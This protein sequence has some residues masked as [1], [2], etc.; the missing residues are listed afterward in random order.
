MAEL[1]RRRRLPDPLTTLFEQQRQFILDPSRRKAAFVARR[2]GKSFAI[3]AYLIRECLRT[4]RTK[5][6]YYGLTRESAWGVMYLHIIDEICRK[7]RLHVHINQ[8]LQTVR[9]DNQSIIKFTGDDADDKQIDKALGGKYRLVVFDECQSINHDL[10]RWI[11]EKLGPAMVDV[12]GTICLC[13]TAGNLMGDR[14]WYRVTRQDGREREPGW[15]VHSWTPFDNP[16]MADR[17]RVELERLKELNPHIEEDPGYRQQ[18]LC[19]W[20]IET[21]G[22]IYRYNPTRN[23][24]TVPDKVVE[25]LSV[26]KGWRY[27]VGMD[28]GFRDDTAFVLGAYHPHDPTLYIVESYKQS[29]MTALAVAGIVN[30]WRAKYKPVHIVGDCQ[31]RQFV[32]TLR[33]QYRIPILAAD[34]MGKSAH[35]AIMNSALIAGAIKVVE[36]RNQALIK[37][38]NE[39]NWSEPKRLLGIWEEDQTKDNHLADAALYLHQ[40]YAVHHRAKP[41]P[42]VDPSPWR[43]AAE[44]EL[45]KQLGQD[46]G[47]THTGQSEIYDHLDIMPDL[48]RYRKGGGNEGTGS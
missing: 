15:S 6:L 26:A 25:L 24:L 35:I 32:E 27:L 46:E 5:C 8:V 29:D 12:D 18:W 42:E 9:F 14:Y 31:A 10:A 36:E 33:Q 22:R 39:L 45:R 1:A 44:N 4:P 2:S 37:E 23:A 20:V 13:G 48:A 40:F 43:T 7:H 47:P 21:S 16:H 19:Q 3:G 28:F 11:N 41:P 30:E 38:W 17:V 34:K